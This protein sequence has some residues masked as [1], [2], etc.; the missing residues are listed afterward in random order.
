MPA[1]IQILGYWT[2]PAAFVQQCRARYGNRFAL[3]IRVP[4]KPLYVLTDPDE[5]KQMFQ[6]PADVLHTG[7]GSATIE[8]FTGQTG[9]A[10]LDEDEHDVRRRRLNPSMHGPALK[11]IEASIAEM[12]EQDIASWPRGE[13][14]PLHPLIHRFT[15]KVI[16]E[17]IFGRQPPNR[18]DEMLDVL[19]EMMSFN[20]RPA[21]TMM[22]H[23]MPPMAVRLLAAFRPTGLHH[24]LELRAHADSLIA[25][26]I[27]ERR[28]AGTD[29]NDMLSMMLN[30]TRDDGA[31]L[32]GVEMRDEM[33]TIFLAGTETTATALAWGLQYLS[34]EPAVR[35][36]LVAEI[37]AG[38]DDAYL[39]AT[40]QEVLRVRPS[41]PQIIPRQVM[42]P[43]EIG[44]VRFEPGS[45]L[46]ASAFLLHRDPSVYPD[47]LSFRPERFL[48]RGPGVYTWIPFGGGRIRCL[49]SAIAI[50]EMKHVIRQVLARYELCRVDSQPEAP[51][52]RSVGTV[53]AN[54]MRVTLVDR[55]REFSLG[56]A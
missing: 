9:L 56:A 4:P 17:V 26:A 40:V 55:S 20:N 44:G 6:A 13:E 32:S 38:E 39:T 16:R 37:D 36:R 28:S 23:R 19:T 3:R 50:L 11:R 48:D 47:P 42:K 5:I 34:R 21:S 30:M 12:A 1:L 18:A 15:L 35:D 33:M 49:G 14:M 31:P 2:R 41:I 24:F 8:K 10:W 29:G 51:R 7:N 25:E 53:P 27:Q 52:S 43:I 45:L 22:I 54:G 46:W